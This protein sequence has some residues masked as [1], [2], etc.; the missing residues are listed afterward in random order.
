MEEWDV[1]EWDVEEERPRVEDFPLLLSPTQRM[2][3]LMPREIPCR[4]EVTNLVTWLSSCCQI[5]VEIKLKTA[6]YFR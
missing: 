2:P 6:K 4:W 1:E 3:M 5:L